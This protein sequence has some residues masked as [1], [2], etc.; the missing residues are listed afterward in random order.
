M[1]TTEEIA[2]SRTL[3]YV[4]TAANCHPI[5]PVTDVFVR[6]SVQTASTPSTTQADR[7]GERD[8]VERL[9]AELDAANSKIA[10]MDQEL[11]QSR[12]TKHT[13]DQVVGNVSDAG[14]PIPQPLS[15]QGDEHVTGPSS[16]MPTLRQ[17]MIRNNSWQMM[18]DSR[19]DTSDA[20]SAGG[21]NRARAIW[22]SKPAFGSFHPPGLTQHADVAANTSWG[23]RPYGQTFVNTQLPAS[24]PPDITTFRAAQLADRNMPEPGFLMAP[25]A[26][27]RGLNRA[28]NRSQPSHPYSSLANASDSSIPQAQTVNQINHHS[29]PLGD[30][31][32]PPTSFGTPVGPSNI[33]HIFTNYPSPIGT[34]L[35]PH[36]PEFTSVTPGWKQEVSL[37][38]SADRS[39]TKYLSFVRQ[40]HQRDRPT[41]PLRSL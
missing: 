20:L 11:A 28:H 23:P 24:A 38:S 27:R 5:T 32:Y 40:V 30:Y 37:A 10:R 34:P 39:E 31:P 17:G 22:G 7:L 18:D 26:G 41:C 9:R 4:V 25:P 12:I 29:A 33:G 1:K 21:F 16:V 35:S 36:A 13:L 19:S 8:D 2:Y 6:D 15:L 3:D 14:S